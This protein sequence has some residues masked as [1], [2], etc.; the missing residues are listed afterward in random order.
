M[1]DDG[2]DI[3]LGHCLGR[4]LWAKE[5][6]LSSGEECVLELLKGRLKNRCGSAES[7]SML[8]VQQLYREN[9]TF[10]CRWLC[11]GE[12]SAEKIPVAYECHLPASSC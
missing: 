2:E 9:V 1:T 4:S 3:Q 8:D 7:S 12:L 5:S 10:L 11:G 6:D